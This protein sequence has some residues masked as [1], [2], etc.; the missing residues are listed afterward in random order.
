MGAGLPEEQAFNRVFTKLMMAGTGLK[1]VVGLAGRSGMGMKA[2]ARGQR[3]LLIPS[4]QNNLRMFPKKRIH[5]SV[6]AWNINYCTNKL[7]SL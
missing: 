6:Y 5:L 2:Q 3:V 4:Q 1:D 7:C